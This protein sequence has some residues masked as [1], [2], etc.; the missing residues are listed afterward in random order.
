MWNKHDTECNKTWQLPINWINQKF[1]VKDTTLKHTDVV[2]YFISAK[3]NANIFTF[4]KW[5]RPVKVL[6]RPGGGVTYIKTY[7]FWVVTVFIGHI[8]FF[9]TI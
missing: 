2:T 6:S 1:N 8:Q 7:S 4:M 9:I 3:G 5:K